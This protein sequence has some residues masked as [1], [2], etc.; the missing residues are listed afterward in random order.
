MDLIGVRFR[1]RDPTLDFV[2]SAFNH[3]TM[4]FVQNLDPSKLAL[5]ATVSPSQWA[6]TVYSS[7]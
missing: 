1:T 2:Q 4:D 5:A 6:L 3:N 7:I